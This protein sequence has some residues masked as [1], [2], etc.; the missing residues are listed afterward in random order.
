MTVPIADPVLG[1]AEKERVEA[2]VDD[3][4]L[5]DGPEVRRF[6]DEFADFCGT[7]HG[8]ATS[9]G[10]TALHAA[11]HAL[12]IGSGDRVLTTPFSFVA[13]ANAVR[14]CG[15]DVGFVDVDPETYA[16]DA[17]ALAARLRESGGDIDAVVV[18]HLYGLPADV[19][20]LRD[21]ADEH[22]VALVEDACQA[23]GA[24]FEGERVGSFGDVGCFSFYPTKNATAGEGGM[25]VT[26]DAETADRVRQFVDHG[27]AADGTHETL[28]H[29]F[30][31]TSV[32]A[33]IGR[34]QLDRLP[35]FTETRRDHARYL[36]DAL[37]DLPVT[38][39][40][41]PPGRTHVYNQYTVR[42]DDR[43]QF[44]EVLADAGVDTAVYYP[45][46]IHQEPAYDG[47][48]V[49]ADLSHAERAAN[50]VVSLPVHPALDRA[51][52][53]RVVAAVR[54][55][56]EESDRQSC[57]GSGPTTLATRTEGDT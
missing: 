30:R 21:L 56:A 43:A 4:Q 17:D 20:R 13:T 11:L 9:N 2:V 46:P 49:D 29:N 26:D 51:D 34:V 41:D 31:M 5:A 8:V 22:D 18:V 10:T 57:S 47:V 54:D 39:P 33:A 27:Q 12:G 52:L 6:E 35:D 28:G 37:A 44:R 7:A 55:Y 14:H 53:D 42:T 36:T 1:Q 25:V 15:A 3:G 40:T 16:L 32:A 48:D 50:E 24:T 45:T 19:G 38:T 23:H